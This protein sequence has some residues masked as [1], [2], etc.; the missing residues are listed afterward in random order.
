M[1][2]L[3]AIALAEL[4]AAVTGAVC[5]PGED[6]YVAACNIW[7]GA[8][9]KRP[10]AAVRCTSAT[11]VAVA[12]TWSQRHS[13][14]ISV[15]GGGHNFAGSALCDGGLTIDLSLMRTVTVDPNTCV[16]TCGGGTTWAELDAATQ[17]H[18]LAVPGGFISHT[19]V[20]GLTLGGGLGWLS[21]E[22]GLSCDMLIGA[23]VVTADGRI[24][25]ASKDEHAELFW[26][27]RGGGGNFGVVTR[28]EFALTP[29]S[30]MV[31]FSMFFVG[32][33]QG[34]TLL[35]FARDFIPTLPAGTT[36][37]IGALH[38]PPAPFVPPQHQL[39]PG[40]AL[41]VVGF[42]DAD[43]HTNAIAPIRSAVAPSF[44]LVTPMPYVALQQMFNGS[45]PWGI[46][47]YEKAVH[48]D[49]MS[50]AAIDVIVEHVPRKSSPLSFVPIFAMGGAY[51]RVPE[52][53]VAF[54]GSRRTRFV[55]NIS[56]AAPT[57]ELFAQDT[58]WVRA[59][60]AALVIHAPNIG[61]YVNFM[62]EYDEARVVAA[63]GPDK[64]RRLAG[65]K[66]TYDPHNVFHLNANIKPAR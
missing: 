41:L 61:S 51:A 5:L 36:A 43:V 64:Y 9:Q 30:P 8:V 55:V 59:F 35:R 26:A 56:A 39:Q 28:F 27:I 3:D 63:Y 62:N 16:A 17:A 32:L 25:H 38:A 42:G 14:E 46:L 22:I 23:E 66:A 29:V 45:A 4:G 49:T 47:A 53:A 2:T 50:D 40:Y 1:S 7:N 57:P 52:D 48:L 19:G 10:A 11:D 58:E 31:H 65:I 13:I 44:E 60:W 34:R 33:D 6:G 21:N 37:F 12:L 18:G 54:G 24:L 20:A 15:R